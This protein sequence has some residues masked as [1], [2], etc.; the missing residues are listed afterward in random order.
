LSHPDGAT[1]AR[2]REMM[3]RQLQQMV[4]LIDDFMDVS[5]ITS[6]KLELRR[7]RVELRAVLE[8]AL[9]TIEPVLRQ[10]GHEVL[11]SLPPEPVFLFADSMRLAQA[12]YNTLNNACSYTAGRGT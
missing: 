6:D 5:H 12:F 2:L 9:E 1:V 7:A 10:S 8:S 4:R 3:E 11:V